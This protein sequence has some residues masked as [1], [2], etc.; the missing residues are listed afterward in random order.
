MTFSG[1]PT[2]WTMQACICIGQY[3]DAYA[4]THAQS[5]MFL[6]SL[7]YMYRGKHYSWSHHYTVNSPTAECSELAEYVVQRA[8]VRLERRQKRRVNLLK[9][10]AKLSCVRSDSSLHSQQQCVDS[11]TDTPGH[12]RVV[13]RSADVDM[14]QKAQTH[15]YL[16]GSMGSKHLI[17]SKKMISPYALVA[18][19]TAR[20]SDGDLLHVRG[21]HT[22]D[23]SKGKSCC[24]LEEKL[25]VVYLSERQSVTPKATGIPNAPPA[26]PSPSKDS[27]THISSLK[28]FQHPP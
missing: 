27:C 23:T 24:Q 4:L 10:H 2:E 1:S 5:T 11:R 21:C 9:R 13:P 14:K 12:K 3:G 8:K 22:S 16:A 18:R 28:S 20:N 17:A 19:D 26:T 25:K 7:V 6:H 15:P